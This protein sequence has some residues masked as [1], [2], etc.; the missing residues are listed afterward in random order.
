MASNAGAAAASDD[1]DVT[2]MMI[3]IIDGNYPF[4][5]YL[6]QLCTADTLFA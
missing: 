5:I 4:T 3:M 6:Q 2:M 1:Y